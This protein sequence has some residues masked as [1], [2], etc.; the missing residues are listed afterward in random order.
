VKDFIIQNW[1]SF[2]IV[3]AFLAIIAVLILQKRWGALRAL[4]YRMMLA[5][6]MAFSS[7]EGKAKFEA[8]FLTVYNLIPDWFKIFVPED[9]LRRKLQEW[10]N[11]AKDWA[12]DGI[13]NDSTVGGVG[14]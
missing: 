9:L 5:A 4:A 13:I 6:E 12:D 7:G 8:V 3:I 11:L 14:K 10:F 2:V 1:T